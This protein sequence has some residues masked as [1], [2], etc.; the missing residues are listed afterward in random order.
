MFRVPRQIIP[1]HKLLI[2]QAITYFQPMF[3]SMENVPGA[4][5]EK[6]IKY[7]LIIVS[8]LLQMGYQVS[9]TQTSASLYGDP[10]D[11]ERLI[12]LASKRGYKLPRLLATHGVENKP[13]A[14][15]AG[16][17][18]GDLEDV[19]PVLDTMGGLAPLRNGGHVLYHYKE[20]FTGAYDKR[21]V[22]NRDVPAKTVTKKNTMKHYKHDRPVTVRER[23][24]LQGFP[25]SHKFAG[26][27]TQVSDQIGNAVPVG[28]ATAIGR[29]IVESYNVGYHCS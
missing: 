14:V 28:L 23:A 26:S 16:D 2:L 19:E 15:T 22:L 3:V 18:L 8:S 9:T 11:R 27:K 1:A 12:V 20:D 13:R 4:G 7:L 5:R 17:A 10:Q 25:D 29:A 24:R 21:Y 6:N